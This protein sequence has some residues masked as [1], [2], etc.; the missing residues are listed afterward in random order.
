MLFLRSW[1]SKYYSRPLKDPIL[2]TYT[3]EELYYEYLDKIEREKAAEKHAEEEHDR[4]ENDKEK[5]AVDWAE[6]EEAKELAE[7]KKK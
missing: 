3:V 4:I 1:W 7:I 5:A 2:D 6:Q